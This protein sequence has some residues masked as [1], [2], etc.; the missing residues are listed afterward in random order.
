MHFRLDAVGSYNLEVD[1]GDRRGFSTYTL[2]EVPIFLVDAF[3]LLRQHGMT[4]EGI[5]RKEGNVN[6]I[7]NVW[8]ECRYE[9]MERV[10]KLLEV[11]RELPPGHLGTLS[12]L[13]RQ[14]K[15]VRKHHRLLA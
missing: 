3:R 4:V 5:F 7:K 11:V 14:L 15:Y 8:I 13:M 10:N 1:I 2:R 12:F 6:R 9:G